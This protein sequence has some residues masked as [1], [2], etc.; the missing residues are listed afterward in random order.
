LPKRVRWEEKAT[1]RAAQAARVLIFRTLARWY[2][3]NTL[4]E[5]L[6]QDLQDVASELRQLIQQEH[7]MV[8]Q[9]DFAGYRHLPATDQPHIRDGVV[10]GA[11]RPRRDDGGAIAGETGDAVDAGG[12]EGF[13]EGQ[14]RQDGGE[15]ARQHGLTCTRRTEEQE[16][17][18]RTP[19]ELSVCIGS[20]YSLAV[21]ISLL[22]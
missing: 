8:R 21:T 4:L 17:M 1:I 3:C 18:V 10:G 20:Q 9:R 19:H 7:A 11:T 22:G 5:G 6:T 15:A 14:M 13:G 12:V 16:V 2:A